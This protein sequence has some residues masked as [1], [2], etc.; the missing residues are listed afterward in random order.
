MLS[1][2]GFNIFSSDEGICGNIKYI[3]ER[4]NNVNLPSVSRNI[5]SETYINT[6]MKMNTKDDHVLTTGFGQEM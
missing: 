2:I 1:L 6:N 4:Y 3:I 5:Y